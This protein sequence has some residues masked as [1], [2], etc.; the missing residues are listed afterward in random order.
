[1]AH[2]LTHAVDG[3]LAG[4]RV[5]ICDRDRKWTD[6][7]RRIVQSAARTNAWSPVPTRLISNEAY[8]AAGARPSRRAWPRSWPRPPDATPEYWV[9]APPSHASRAL[10]LAVTR[11]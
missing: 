8:L 11:A 10:D 7:F 3:F 9:I 1:M 6:D 4:H 5:L 2:R